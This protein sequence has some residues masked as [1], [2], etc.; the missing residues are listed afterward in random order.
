MPSPFEFLPEVLSGFFFPFDWVPEKVWAVEAPVEELPRVELDWHL[1]LPFWS[2]QP[3]KPLFDV[4]PNDV[5]ACEVAYPEHYERVVRANISFAIDLMWN[6]D[7][8]LILDGMHRL[9]RL[10]LENIEVARV[11]KIPRDAISLIRR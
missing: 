11:R 4:I 8:L 6:K 9:A 5:L 2:S 3:E 7:R 10:K 1:C